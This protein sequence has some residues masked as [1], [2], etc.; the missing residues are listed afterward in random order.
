M[1]RSNVSNFAASLQENR[2]LTKS[3][4]EEKIIREMNKNH[5]LV[6]S[7]LFHRL[8]KAKKKELE[9]K[10]VNIPLWGYL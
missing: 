9:A 5:A 3:Q 6:K 7:D 2:E 10:S 4:K 1:D 8:P